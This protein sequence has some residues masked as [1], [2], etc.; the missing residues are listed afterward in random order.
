VHSDI[1]PPAHSITQDTLAM[2]KYLQNGGRL[3][4]AGWSVVDNVS[5]RNEL[6]KTFSPGEFVYD[7]L[8]VSGARTGSGADRDFKGADA[9]VA[10]YPPV[11]VDPVKVPLFGNNLI[12]MEILTSFVSGTTTETLYRYRSSAQPPSAFHGQPVALRH[13]D[14]DLK[15]IVLDF[16]LYFLPEDAAAQ[17]LRRALTDLGEIP[18]TV[19][20]AQ[21]PGLL[22]ASFDLA[23]SYPNPLRLSAANPDIQIQYQL[24]V[25]AQ[26]RIIVYNL[27]GQRVA[28]LLDGQK[29]PGFYSL[30]WDGKEITAHPLGC[31]YPLG[32]F[33]FI[34]LSA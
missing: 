5:T 33:C 22:P 14:N 16:P 11:T 12:A 7:V 23:Q 6:S 25:R 30:Q 18:T 1:S 9:V 8:R 24:P 19:A 26:V 15:V 3:F 32:K 31:F 20:E 17:L 13:I 27:A 28:T 29:A 10:N 4:L 21:R 34:H 2:K